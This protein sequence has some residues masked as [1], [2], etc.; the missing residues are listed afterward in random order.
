MRAINVVQEREKKKKA[1][2][3][4]NKCDRAFFLTL[5]G[6][7]PSIFVQWPSNLGCK[8]VSDLG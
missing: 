3:S 6:V 5:D 4:V 2:T 8:N 7:K 1:K